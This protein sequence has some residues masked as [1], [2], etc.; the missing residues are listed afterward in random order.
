MSI[1]IQAFIE[2]NA[3]KSIVIPG[4]STAECVAA[5]WLFNREVNKSETYSAYGAYNLWWQG[6][7]PYIWDSY[8]RSAAPVWGS[9]AIWSGHSGAYP[10]G[11]IGHV[12]QFL[13]DNGNG[14]GQFM[15]QNPGP[16][17]EQTLSMSGIV[18]YLVAKDVESGVAPA[19]GTLTLPG[20]V[21]YWRVYPEGVAP[22]R[23]NEKAAL[24]PMQ[25]GG[26][27]Y[28][29]AGWSQPNVALIDTQMFGR[30]QIYVGPDTPATIQ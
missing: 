30:V 5:F 3:G 24:N 26:L 4:Y 17:R 1:S 6:G 11:G 18:G 21:D 20:T 10:N 13:R 15:S 23:G 16:Y 25:Y 27:T 12:A 29:I 19:G 14:T 2:K 28:A 22:I 8:D 7:N 9:W